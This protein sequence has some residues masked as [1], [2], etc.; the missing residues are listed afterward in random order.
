[1]PASLATN[2][3]S[4]TLNG[5]AGNDQLST[6]GGN[7]LVNGGA[8]TDMIFLGFGDDTFIWN[9]GDGNDI[10]EGSA[11]RDKLVFNGDDSNE[12]VA[13]S[14]NGGRARF[15][16]NVG[17]IS[18][19]L[20]DVEQIDFNALGGADTITVNDLTGTDVVEID[21]N[22]A[23]TLGGTAGDRQVDSVIV[24]GTAGDD[25]IP[26]LGNSGGILVNGDFLGGG[27]LAAFILIRGVEATDSL[28]INGGGGDD[29]IA[30]RRARNARPLQRRRRRRRRHPHRHRGQ[31]PAPRRRGRRHTHRRP[32]PG[33]PRRRPRQQYD[34]PGLIH[35]LLSFVLPYAAR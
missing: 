23:S 25:L 19:D 31:R 1:M 30:G 4:L 6:G 34:R 26:V 8:G 3:I 2:S 17:N 10:V 18:L 24:N 33:R 9:P 22:L 14:N 20:D 28:R 15:T 21:L 27:G 35:L 12:N 16:R 5:G 29:I 13:I 32:R 7:D 11:G